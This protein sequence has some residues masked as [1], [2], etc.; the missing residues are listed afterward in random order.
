MRTTPNSLARLTPFG[1]KVTIS[2]L[3]IVL[4]LGLTACGSNS[5]N[6]LPLATPTDTETALVQPPER[7]D[8][9]AAEYRL[10][11]YNIEHEPDLNLDSPNYK[12]EALISSKNDYTIGEVHYLDS[13]LSVDQEWGAQEI[14]DA[15]I[16]ATPEEAQ[17]VREALNSYDED[18]DLEV[19]NVL[20][21]YGFGEDFNLIPYDREMPIGDK[22]DITRDEFEKIATYISAKDYYQLREHVAALE[23]DDLSVAHSWLKGLTDTQ[24]F[25]KVLEDNGLEIQ[26]Y[27]IQ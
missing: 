19:T 10:H 17:K 15:M 2:T 18:D 8:D 20:A 26:P 25:E 13:L 24:I 21:K 9:P 23:G 5:S 27:D 16:Q 1:G 22:N 3:S 14:M 6:E 7:I 4:A 12:E 11:E